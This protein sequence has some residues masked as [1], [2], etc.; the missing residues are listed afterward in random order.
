MKIY[1]K[2]NL[3]EKEAVID[4]INNKVVI[5]SKEYLCDLYDYGGGRYSLLIDNKSYKLTLKNDDN[6]RISIDNQPLLLAVEDEKQRLVKEL[7]KNVKRKSDL[8]II[9]APIPGLVVK[10]L[11]E[12]GQGVQMGDALLILEAMKMENVIKADCDCIVKKINVAEKDTVQIIKAL[13][14]LNK[15]W[16][17]IKLI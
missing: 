9:K 13:I 3:G 2:T 11:V 6:L 7:F 8:Q 10:I 1:I 4:E 17:T 12:E 5:E 16:N 14:S 15:L